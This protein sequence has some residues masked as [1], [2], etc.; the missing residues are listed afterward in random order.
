MMVTFVVNLFNGCSNGVTTRVC[1]DIERSFIQP[2][3]LHPNHICQGLLE[4]KE[5]FHT[6]WCRLELHLRPFPSFTLPTWGSSVITTSVESYDKLET[7]A[8]SPPLAHA[9]D[10]LSEIAGVIPPVNPEVLTLKHNAF[11]AQL[12]LEEVDLDSTSVGS[13]DHTILSMPP[14]HGP[15]GKVPGTKPSPNNMPVSERDVQNLQRV[16]WAKAEGIK[17]RT[18]LDLVKRIRKSSIWS[19]DDDE[20]YTLPDPATPLVYS[21][22]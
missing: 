12:L 14:S 4:T 15:T 1:T 10:H 17:R 9:D 8:V 7:C 20:E 11:L 3:N 21:L 19:E 6:F 22:N 5:C 13:R 2:W 16:L 18:R